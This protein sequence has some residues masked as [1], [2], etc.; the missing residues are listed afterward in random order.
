M[1]INPL[2]ALQARAPDIQGSFRNALLN[3]QGIQGLRES[4]AQAEREAQ[5]QPLRD[6]LLQAQTTTAEQGV[7]TPQQLG[8]QRNLARLESVANF[9]QFALPGLQAG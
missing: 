3:V 4:Q 5:L 9:S 2:I 6:R 1:A 8:S 7:Q